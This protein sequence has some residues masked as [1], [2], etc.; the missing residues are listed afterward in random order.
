VFLDRDGVLVEEVFYPETGEIEAPLRPEDVR[1]MPNAAGAVQ[2]LSAAGYS[3]VVISNQAG[4]A[5]GKTTLRA[6]WLAHE[7]FVQ[8]LLAEGAT[9]DG[10]L[11]AYGH[12][13]GVTPHFSGPSLDRKPAPYNLFVAAAQLNL[14][15]ARSWLVGDRE[16]DILCAEAAGVRPIFIGNTHH[17]RRHGIGVI[18]ATSLATAAALILSTDRRISG[19]RGCSSQQRQSKEPQ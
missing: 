16:T 11:Y 10:C 3:L 19:V 2:A 17:P 8:L 7:R 4:Y 13:A 12:P 5:K 15:L 14:D 6:L 9:L 18:T 1:L